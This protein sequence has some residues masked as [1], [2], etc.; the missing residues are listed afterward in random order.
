MR[1][2]FQH[3]IILIATRLYFSLVVNSKGESRLFFWFSATQLAHDCLASY[4]GH[5]SWCA[6][7][8]W[9]FCIEVTCGNGNIHS[10]TSHMMMM[11]NKYLTNLK[12]MLDVREDYQKCYCLWYYNCT[13]TYKQCN[14]K[15]DFWFWFSF[16]YIFFN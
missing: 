4:R 1:K 15:V 6:F 14:C 9:A 2:S 11:M 8:E 5:L 16:L 12:N 10:R 3:Y 7:H 13:H